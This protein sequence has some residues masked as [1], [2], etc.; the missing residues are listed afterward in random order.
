MKAYSNSRKD[1]T[2]P[3]IYSIAEATSLDMNRTFKNQ[4]IIFTGESGSGKTENFKEY[5]KYLST[6][7]RDGF[8]KNI[9]DAYTIL[10]SFGNAS[11][12]LNSNTSLFASSV[13]IDYSFMKVIG[14]NFNCFL[15]NSCRAYGTKGRNFNIFYQLLS[16]DEYR[17][18]Y[19]LKEIKDYRILPNDFNTLNDANLFLILLKCLNN[20]SIPT[21]KLFSV[22]SLILHLGNVSNDEKEYEILEEIYGIKKEQLNGLNL[23]QEIHLLYFNLFEY[24]VKALN[25]KL[26]PKQMV[27]TSITLVDFPGF[28]VEEDPTFGN[29]TINYFNDLMNN[30]LNHYQFKKEQDTYILERIDWKATEFDLSKPRMKTQTKLIENIQNLEDDQIKIDHLFTSVNYKNIKNWKDMSHLKEGFYKEFSTPFNSFEKIQKLSDSIFSISSCTKTQ[31][32]VCIRPNNLGKSEIVHPKLLLN[33]IEKHN[34]QPIIKLTRKGFLDHHSPESFVKRYFMLGNVEHLAEEDEINAKCKIILRT[35]GLSSGKNYKIGKNVIFLKYGQ[36]YELED[37]RANRIIELIVTLQ[38]YAKGYCARKNTQKLKQEKEEKEFDKQ[39]ESLPRSRKMRSAT[40]TGASIQSMERLT[41]N[42]SIYELFSKT[43]DDW[44]PTIS[45]KSSMTLSKPSTPQQ[46]P[47]ETPKVDEEKKTNSEL[48]LLNNNLRKENQMI[49]NENESLSIEMKQMKERLNTLEEENQEYKNQVT[50]K[51]EKIL[52]LQKKVKEM[53]KLLEGKESKPNTPQL[54]PVNSLSLK[55]SPQVLPL[56]KS[57]QLSLLEKSPQTLPLE[58]S[59]KLNTL[60]KS[61]QEVPLEKIPEEPVMTENVESKPLTPKVET[62]VKE[63]ALIDSIPVVE[64]PKIETLT[65]DAPVVQ[66]SPST[67][68][69]AEP[70]LFIPTLK[71]IGNNIKVAIQDKQD[72]LLEEV[73]LIETPNEIHTP[74]SLVTPTSEPIL[75]ENEMPKPRKME[76]K[77][78][79]HEELKKEIISHPRESASKRDRK[80]KIETFLTILKE[81]KEEQPQSYEELEILSVEKLFQRFENNENI[82][83]NLNTLHNLIKSNVTIKPYRLKT[84]LPLLSNENENIVTTVAQ[85]LTLIIVD[86]DISKEVKTIDQFQ[87]IIQLLSHKNEN[88]CIL[89]SGIILNIIFEKENI[90]IVVKSGII[91]PLVN[92]LRLSVHKDL[93]SNSTMILSFISET[94]I[95]KDKIEFKDTVT[96]LKDPTNINTVT[97]LSTL[98]PRLDREMILSLGI[99][100]YIVGIMTHDDINVQIKTLQIIASIHDKLAPEFSEQ[101]KNGLSKLLSLTKSSQTQIQIHSL[102]AL[103]LLLHNKEVKN[104]IRA[105][106]GIGNLIALLE[107][108]NELIIEKSCICLANLSNSNSVNQLMI[109]QLDGLP[110]LL[111]LIYHSNNILQKAAANTLSNLLID[112]KNKQFISSQLPGAIPAIMTLKSGGI[113]ESKKISIPRKTEKVEDN[114]EKKLEKKTSFLGGIFK[115]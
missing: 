31:K 28:Q 110:P 71:V 30:I 96:K 26:A 49:R 40:M 39:L 55:K 70:K 12:K 61:P 65:K 103:G 48:L 80:K 23:D 37:M 47:K 27:K 13:E 97:S 100:E 53:E 108:K 57:P 90:P 32:V 66:D 56:E 106:H 50:K 69:N 81:S 41:K 109:R 75:D 94:L 11:T 19:K 74:Q 42:E 10:E 35:C 59:P 33:Q 98:L 7:S 115:I 24:L 99:Y 51:I 62:L 6:T 2:P 14:A 111:E 29:F 89:G 67:E 46:S 95:K 84:L 92:I 91:D 72:K 5:L 78:S 22:V 54:T 83:K 36:V 16:S 104:A 17:K 64:T 107:S 9:L 102:T 88:I 20:L 3:H 60:E 18:K 87:S 45:K 15:F 85:I 38:A 52:A 43:T 82:E 58:K 77:R 44:S 76:R 114:S 25:S 1:T 101:L 4:L 73:T 68:I 34:L 79:I 105:L 21:D 113:V 86:R 93:T 63:D 8:Y 112:S